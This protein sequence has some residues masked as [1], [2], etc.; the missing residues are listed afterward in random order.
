VLR[1]RILLRTNGKSDALL[2]VPKSTILDDLEGS[3]CTLFAKHAPFFFTYLLYLYSLKK[4][5]KSYNLLRTIQKC[6]SILYGYSLLNHIILR[7]S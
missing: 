3:L 2:L 7:V 6:C 5:N 4:I 1:L